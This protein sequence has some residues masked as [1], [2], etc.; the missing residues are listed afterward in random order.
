MPEGKRG[1]TDMKSSSGAHYEG[2]DHLRAVAA[3]LVVLWHFSRPF[4]DKPIALTPEIGLIAQGHS[5]VALF[6]TLSGYL[7]AKL[8]GDRAID[9]RAF[10]LN[11]ALRLLP[12][13]GLCLLLGYLVQSPADKPA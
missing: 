10:A 7:F 8:V 5:G 11:R 6:M 4:S 1:F 9:F 13:F 3:F 12:L 2:L